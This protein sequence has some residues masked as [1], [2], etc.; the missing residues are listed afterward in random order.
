MALEK[1]LKEYGLKEKHAKVYLACL[2]LG[3]GSVLKISQKAALPRSTTEVILN[4]LQ[5]KGFVSSF[6]KKNAR[7]FSTEDPKK[8]IS[9][10]KAKAELLEKAL[11]D[12]RELYAR[13]NVIPTVR[14]YQGKEGIRTVFSEI[15]E[16]KPKE[17]LAFSSVDD[18]F[19]LLG[20]EFTNFVQK[21]GALGIRSRV[22][23]RESEKA[24]ER[25]QSGEKQ[26]R[27]VRLISQSYEHS[28]LTYVWGNKIAMISLKHEWSVLIIESE[29][30]AKSQKMLFEALWDSL[31]VPKQS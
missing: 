15:L 30:L 3:S 17:L 7:Y 13:S 25:V 23:L 26:L 1:V 10:A 5:E 28:G 18:L 27:Q 4:A 12:F 14:F 6:K 2:E 22:I 11:P 8:I 31:P 19:D 20:K 29:E 24:W 9:N 16:D 21:R